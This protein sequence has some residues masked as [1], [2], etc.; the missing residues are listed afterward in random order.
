[1]KSDAG[2]KIILEV[3]VT[4]IDKQGIWLL[5]DDKEYFLPFEKFPWFRAATVGEIHNVQ[6][7]KDGELHWPDLNLNLSIESF[8]HAEHVPQFG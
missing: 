1:M 7:G 6:V 3:E 8:G 4:Q 2:G 5:I